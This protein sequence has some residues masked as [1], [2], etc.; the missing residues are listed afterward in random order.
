MI[1]FPRILVPCFLLSAAA[2]SDNVGPGVQV[3]PDYLRATVSSAAL[4]D[5]DLPAPASG[6]A[7]PA[8]SGDCA[9]N[10]AGGCTGGGGF[11]QRSNLQLDFTTNSAPL[12]VE[13]VKV[14]L[15]SESSGNEL[16]VLS[17][18]APKVWATG[19]SSGYVAWD[20]QIV[21]SPTKASYSMKSPNWAKLDGARQSGVSASE[22]YFLNV[23]IRA[24]GGYEITVKSGTLSRE[25]QIAT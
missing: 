7:A 6:F 21:S 25:P 19:N 16:E 11:C 24:A 12:T 18:S 15:H 10:D 1:N 2:C 9:M 8:E 23:T 20:Q 17:T 3:N 13:I 22:K 5:C 4:G 14:A